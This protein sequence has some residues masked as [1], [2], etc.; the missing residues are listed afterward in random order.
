M[1]RRGHLSRKVANVKIR[2]PPVASSLKKRQPSPEKEV[3]RQQFEEGEEGEDEGQI[4]DSIR[5]WTG[6]IVTFTGVDDKVS[7][8]GSRALK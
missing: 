3:W 6:V 4:G 8:C 2:P 5:P 1:N 7:R